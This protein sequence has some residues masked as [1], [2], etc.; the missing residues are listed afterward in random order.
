MALRPCLACR[1]PT[2]GT[3]CPP[4]QRQYERTRRPDRHVRYPAEYEH[5]R[6]LLLADSP[7]CWSCGLSATT[8][9]HI[10]PRSRGGGHDLS[11]L[12]P[13]CS[14]CNSSRGARG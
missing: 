12:R 9:D 7:R 3:R 10:V 8:A 6:A 5:N 13:A 11:N 14:S 4:C 2:T 1:T